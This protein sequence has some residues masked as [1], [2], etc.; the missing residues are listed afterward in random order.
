MD[1][2]DFPGVAIQK[3][4]VSSSRLDGLPEEI[5]MEICGMVINQPPL[6]SDLD[7]LTVSTKFNRVMKEAF[8]MAEPDRIQSQWKYL[9]VQMHMF[10]TIHRLHEAF[11]LETQQN[12][13]NSA[14]KI[15]IQFVVNKERYRYFT[16]ILMKDPAI[17]A[18]FDRVQALV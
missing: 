1:F 7:I 3:Q 14:S 11:T 10:E 12:R 15:C 6:S 18:K 8:M 4:L 17:P 2:C 16:V 9:K 13:I 5:L